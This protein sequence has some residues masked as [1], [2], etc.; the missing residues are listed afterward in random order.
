MKKKHA[1][2]LALAKLTEQTTICQVWINY[3]M[4]PGADAF[5]GG[6]QRPPSRIPIDKV[7]APWKKTSEK[8]SVGADREKIQV[9]RRKSPGKESAG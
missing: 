9:S 4:D 1:Q 2:R 3:A 8:F 5:E 6:Q 7:A